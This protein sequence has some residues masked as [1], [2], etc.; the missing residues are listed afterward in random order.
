MK[1]RHFLL[2]VAAGAGLLAAGC[3][4]TAGT[5][6][7]SATESIEAAAKRGT[8]PNG[9]E[10][11]I[12]RNSNP[13]GKLEL[14]LSVRTGSLQ[15][16]EGL[17][18]TAH[19]LEHLQFLGTSRY[20]AG[21]IVHFAESIG[22]AFG[23]EVN[24]YT[25]YGETQYKLSLPADDPAAIEK[26]ID[27]LEDWA[28]GPVVDQAQMDR[29]RNV[30]HEEIRLSRESMQGRL[31]DALMEELT[32]GS[33]YEG[34]TVIGTHESL[35]RITAADIEQFAEAGYTADRMTI[36]A[37]GDCDEDE[38]IRSLEKKFVSGFGGT[39]VAR[40]TETSIPRFENVKKDSWRVHEDSSLGQDFYMWMN[41]ENAVPSGILEQ[42]LLDAR[43]SVAAQAVNQRL[44]AL[45]RDTDT[46]VQKAFM[47]W[48]TSLGNAREYGI[49]LLPR[50][51][52]DE[53]AL[54]SLFVEL[55]KIEEHGI[56]DQEYELGIKTLTDRHGAWLTQKMNVTS[57]QKADA[58]A[59][60]LVM[61]VMYPF[62]ESASDS[63]L[64]SAKKT[65]KKDVDGWIQKYAYPSPSAVVS[66]AQNASDSGK[67]DG[68]KMEE[69]TARYRKTATQ[70][71]A[72]I[73]MKELIPN[74]P[75]PGTI[76][77][78]ESVSGTPFMRWTLSNGIVLYTYRNNLTKN[79]FRM[80]A[81][82]PGGLS[83]LAD[84][85]YWNGVMASGILG[86][87]G[88]ADL[89]LEEL[90]A[91]LTGKRARVSFTYKL[92]DV[93]LTGETD[94]ADP[95]DM[96]RFFKLVHAHLAMPRRDDKAEKAAVENVQAW[97]RANAQNSEYL[98]SKEIQDA[99]VGFDPRMA[100]PGSG[101][102]PSLSGDRAA[103]VKAR[104]F[105]NPTGL[106]F[107]VCG[108]YLESRLEDLVCRWIASLPAQEAKQ[109]MPRDPGIRTVAGP[110]E[111]VLAGGKDASAKAAL[112]LVEEGP[113]KYEY[114]HY[115]SVLAEVLKIRLREV[116][117]EDKGGVYG[118]QVTVNQFKQPFSRTL[119]TI[120]FTCAP[121][122]R[123]E[124]EEAAK[125]ELAAIASGK[126]DERAWEAAL[127]IHQKQLEENMRTNEAWPDLLTEAVLN[128]VPLSELTMLKDKAKDLSREEFNAWTA[129]V[130]KPGKVLSFALE[131]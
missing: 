111:K 106:T 20:K 13:P 87:N 110:Y 89:S 104:L 117:R 24:A 100:Q 54:E 56:T 109:E 46:G 74:P 115:S 17:E 80:K 91:Y 3:G 28:Q 45:E 40:N 127:A 86:N 84:D 131:P 49:Q 19:F 123:I 68:Q 59:Q 108:D 61:G 2:A 15:D 119:I 67:I 29:E 85:E 126:I 30:V 36:I 122:K 47:Y 42:Q 95:D 77:S 101:G 124:L 125:A 66:V 12:L 60:T 70:A 96:E 32:R 76:A 62:G 121:E 55:R 120:D 82:A 44:G 78:K 83:I 79:D 51:G 6:Q 71:G 41:V 10:Y 116:L 88:A 58:I 92:A 23:P 38:L 43:A 128:D 75:A 22:M 72:E 21:D 1:L 33:P 37:V 64:A 129:S 5:V 113:W 35:D 105:G 26:G 93:Q 103:A 31:Q 50:K 112:V 48:A 90:G 53:K 94:P 4:S 102:I 99:L 9:M 114:R 25:S 98:Y 8:L 69:L 73:A 16:R 65:K 97:Y 118:W 57:D 81:V 52:M 34:K 63:L 7:K 107:I 18:G 39:A 11:V 14:R 27:I 130:L